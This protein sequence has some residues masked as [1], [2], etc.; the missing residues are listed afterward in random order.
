MTLT[1]VH[2]FKIK[3]ICGTNQDPCETTSLLKMKAE[4]K[5]VKTDT[6]LLNFWALSWLAAWYLFSGEFIKNCDIIDSL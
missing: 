1:E 6:G 2:G 4:K 3:S 5:A